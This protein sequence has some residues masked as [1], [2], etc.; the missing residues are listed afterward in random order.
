MTWEKLLAK[1]TVVNVKKARCSSCGQIDCHETPVLPWGKHFLLCPF[2]LSLKEAEAS[3]PDA[4][5][6]YR[7]FM[8]GEVDLV[9]APPERIHDGEVRGGA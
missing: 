6:W 1:E 5:S 9:F 2:C 3:D 8:L 7:T 4:P